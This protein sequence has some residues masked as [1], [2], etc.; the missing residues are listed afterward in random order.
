LKPS[1]ILFLILFFLSNL[2]C[3]DNPHFYKASQFFYRPRLAEDN[4]LSITGYTN[5]GG[6]DSGY[7]EQREL[8]PLLSIWG[9]QN[10]HLI[11][12]G[13]PQSTLNKFPNSIL[14]DLWQKNS[15]CQFGQLCFSGNFRILSGDFDI[16]K[17]GVDGFFFHIHLPIRKLKIYNIKISD[18]STETNAGPN[19]DFKDWQSFISNFD[20]NINKYG[21]SLN[22]ETS[23]QGAGDLSLTFGKTINYERT[24]KLDFIDASF[25]LGI[26]FPTG[27][28]AN[29][30][31]PF[32]LPTGYNKHYGIPIASNLSIG[33]FEW[34]TIGTYL[35]LLIFKSK[36]ACI[37]MKT[38][39]C[40]NGPIK[41][42]FGEAT[43]KRGPL[44]TYG[45]FIEADHIT[46]GFSFLFGY[47]LNN[48]S[49]TEIC[50]CDNTI[51]D[52][53]IVNSDSMLE[54]WQMSTINFI[55][56]YDF[57]DFEYPNRPKIGFTMDITAKGKQ[58][59]R[60]KIGGLYVGAD[61]SCEF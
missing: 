20:N 46:R 49:K 27:K 55:L 18:L 35:N 23:S 61:I 59:F 58:I 6:G 40:Q 53:K 41:L 24:K 28:A 30:F 57:A 7:N 5:W 26:L 51:F 11:A 25:Q 10:M 52:T 29:P 33:L 4:L 22:R 37:G 43:I 14:N 16:Q 44:L 34:L 3:L 12:Q 13:V 36:H 47:Q 32:S 60:T 19:I 50:P 21:L 15:S 39:L 2:K 56:E 45:F 38:E 9:Q 48:Q 1:R 54:G 8:V 17:N 42:A 31:D